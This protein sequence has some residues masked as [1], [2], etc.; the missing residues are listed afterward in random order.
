MANQANKKDPTETALLAVQEA[1]NAADPKRNAAQP[2]RP[3][4][5]GRGPEPALTEPARSR[6]LRRAAK[7]DIQGPAPRAGP[8]RV[9][10][11]R[12]RACRP[13]RRQRRPPVDRPDSADRCSA[14]RRATSYVVATLFALAWVAGGLILTTLYL[15]DLRAVGEGA[16]GDARPDRHRRAAAGADPVLLRPRPYGLALAGAAPDRAIDGRRRH[17]PGRAGRRRPRI[18]RDGGPGDPPRGRRHGRR[19]RTRAGAGL[20]T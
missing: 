1:L 12:R 9:R 4:P 13:A 15:P 6:T 17:A 14:A 7:P 16:L 10:R 19:R 20:R 5:D 2:C 11:D 3:G 18:R 8:V